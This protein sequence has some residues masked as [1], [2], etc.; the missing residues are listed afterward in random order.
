[1]TSIGN[2]AFSGCSGFEE[3]RYEGSIK[4]WIQISFGYAANPIGVADNA[5]LFINGEVVTDVIIFLL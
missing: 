2:G 5:N 4:D 3:V 1:M